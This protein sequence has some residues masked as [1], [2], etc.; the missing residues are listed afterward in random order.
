MQ[1]IPSLDLLVVFHCINRHAVNPTIIE[2]RDTVT[3]S[4]EVLNAT[5]VAKKQVCMIDGIRTAQMTDTYILVKGFTFSKSVE[6]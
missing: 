4:S 2:K 6:T 5:L 3:K 1:T